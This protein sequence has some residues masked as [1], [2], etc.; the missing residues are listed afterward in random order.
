MRPNLRREENFKRKDKL[1]G[2]LS[3]LRPLTIKQLLNM[4]VLATRMKLSIN[5]SQRDGSRT[6]NSNQPM[7]LNTKRVKKIA[8]LDQISMIL[9]H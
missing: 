3:D 8:L 7:I 2:A 9:H 4:K 5:Q 6:R 1:K